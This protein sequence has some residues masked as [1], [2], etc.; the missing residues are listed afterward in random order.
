VVAVGVPQHV[1]QR[2]YYRQQV[3][4]RGAQRRFYLA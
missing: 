3:I 1:T 2:G 4:F